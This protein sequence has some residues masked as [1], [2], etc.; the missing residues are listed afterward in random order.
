MSATIGGLFLLLALLVR[1][2]IKRRNNSKPGDA[3]ILQVAKQSKTKNVIKEIDDK[4]IVIK[5]SSKMNNK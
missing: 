3:F 2:A 5:L 4:K 1:W